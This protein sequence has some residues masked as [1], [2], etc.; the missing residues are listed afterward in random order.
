MGSVHDKTDMRPILIVPTSPA[1]SSPQ[2]GVL[3]A[4]PRK[5]AGGHTPSG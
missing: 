5:M 4:P 2:D 1:A 3:R